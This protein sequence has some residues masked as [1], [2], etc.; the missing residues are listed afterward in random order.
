MAMAPFQGTMEVFTGDFVA[1]VES[2]AEQSSGTSRI[3]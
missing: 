2:N 3:E 1:I